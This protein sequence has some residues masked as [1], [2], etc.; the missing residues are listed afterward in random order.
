MKR[1]ATVGAMLAALALA[2]PHGMLAQEQV[3]GETVEAK[4]VIVKSTRIEE[5]VQQVPGSITVVEQKDV[6]LGQQS[7]GISE[8]L[9]GVPGVQVQNQENFA[10]D[11]RLSIRGFGARAAF[12]IQGIKVFVDGLPETTADGQT[13]ID[14]LEMGAVD[15][16]E[17]L[18]GPSSALYGASAGG[19]LFITTEAPPAEPMIE[20]KVTAGSFGYLKEQVKFGQPDQAGGGVIFNLTNLT[21]D[22][23]REFSA[24]EARNFNGKIVSKFNESSEL[25]TVLN[26]YNSPKAEDPQG[27]T[28]EEFEDDPQQARPDGFFAGAETQ[29]TGEEVVEG[30]AGLIWDKRLDADLLTFSLYRVFRQFSGRI[31]PRAIE[32]ERH[33]V[34]GAA[35]YTFNHE[36]GGSANSLA[37]GADVQEQTDRRRNFDNDEGTYGDM[38]LNQVEKAAARG[39]FVSDQFHVTERLLLAASLRNDSIVVSANDKFKDDGNQSG[40]RTFEENS[41]GLGANFAITKGLNA[42]V[43]YSQAFEIPTLTQLDNPDGTGGF[44][45]DLDPQVANSIELGVRGRSGDDLNYEAVVFQIIGTDEIVLFQDA[46]SGIDYYRNVGETERTGAEL[47]ARFRVLAPL[48]VVASYTYLKAEY[49]KYTAKVEQDDEIVTLNNKGNRIPGIPENQ[50]FLRLEYSHPSGFYLFPEA[51]Y[52]SDIEVD[53]ANSDSADAY[54]VVNVRTGYVTQLG[55]NYP[56]S[57]F[58]GVNNLTDEKYNQSIRINDAGGRFFEPAPPTNYYLGVSIGFAGTP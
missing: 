57:V 36:L 56:M 13:N 26:Y 30:K 34:G 49:T 28:R 17:V 11:V 42:F 32:F 27:L 16:I 51:N 23:Y 53:D 14:S 37:L 6:Q 22:G 20:G 48:A 4:P 45:E 31:V 41:Y 15:R 8:P 47:S 9:R 55:E 7:K 24:Y 46:D 33:V 35:Q 5:D 1:I 43:N 52:V 40:D 39:L 29:D 25:T 3:Q 44:N 12:G 19:L 10:G 58:A 50:A 18:R 54:T 38:S 2:I 21:Y